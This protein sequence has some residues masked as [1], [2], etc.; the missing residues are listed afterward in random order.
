[1][2]QEPRVRKYRS[3][4]YKGIVHV[5]I[6]IRKRFLFVEFVVHIDRPVAIGLVD[7]A[8]AKTG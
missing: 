3:G 4:T 2:L 8:T 5:T 6:C 7:D 1:M